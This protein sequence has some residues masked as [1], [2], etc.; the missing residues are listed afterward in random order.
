MNM[1]TDAGGHVCNE[2]LGADRRKSASKKKILTADARA[3]T[4]ELRSSRCA[5][6]DSS[7]VMRGSPNLHQ[8]QANC[9]AFCF[10]AG[11]KQWK[12]LQLLRADP[13]S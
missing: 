13:G 2:I 3:S 10:F 9:G 11:V 5:A 7:G 12:F 4:L 1:G 8:I 6:I